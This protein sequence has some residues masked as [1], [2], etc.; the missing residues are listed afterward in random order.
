MG[1]YCERCREPAPQFSGYDRVV[2]LINQRDEALIAESKAIAE[3]AKVRDDLQARS[4]HLSICKSERQAAWD[5]LAK[6]KAVRDAAVA[7]LTDIRCD[8]Q[9]EHWHEDIDAARLVD[10]LVE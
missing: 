9:C 2:V 8:I 6:V 1:L 5:E 7:L 3:L 10:R 4:D